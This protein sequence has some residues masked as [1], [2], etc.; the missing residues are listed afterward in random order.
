M[1]LVHQRDHVLGAIFQQLRRL[2]CR[3]HLQITVN[4]PSS[5]VLNLVEA[6][7]QHPPGRAT[8]EVL[9]APFSP[10]GDPGKER[11]MELRQWQLERLPWTD[12][13]VIWDDDH[14]LED[15]KEAR[16]LLHTGGFDLVY[17]TK[18]FFWDSPETYT[19]H[20]PVHRSV[21]FFRR[22]PGDSFPLDRVIHAPRLIHDSSREIRDLEG[23]LLDYGY[24]YPEDRFRAWADYK[25]S[26]KI[27]AS[28]IGLILPPKLEQWTGQ[29]PILNRRG[30]LNCAG[31]N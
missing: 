29:V 10:V 19:T 26:G 31:K 25:R 8:V 18:K 1:L 9:Q 7:V 24:L 13:G 14:V 12:Y 27:D 21:F 15:H 23:A 16:D 4:R 5:S 11:F 2:K 6:V 22:I 30:R 28:T 20:L 17:A 3:T